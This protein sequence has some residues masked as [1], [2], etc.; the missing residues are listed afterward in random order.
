MCL[1]PKLKN[2]G[3]NDYFNKKL[4]DYMSDLMRYFITFF[5]PRNPILWSIIRKFSHDQK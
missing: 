3:L 4:K 2:D 1:I 5:F